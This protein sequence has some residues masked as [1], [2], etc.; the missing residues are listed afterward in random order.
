VPGDQARKAIIGLFSHNGDRQS[1]RK[2]SAPAAIGQ[3]PCKPSRLSGRRTQGCGAQARC[4]RKRHQASQGRQRDEGLELAERLNSLVTQSDGIA[5]G[6]WATLP[7]SDAG[8][9]AVAQACA[10]LLTSLK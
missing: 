5:K 8:N 7:G 4:T 1:G 3:A 2:R 6:G 9:S 10:N